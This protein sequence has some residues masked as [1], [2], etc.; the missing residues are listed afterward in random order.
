MKTSV[1]SLGNCSEQKY[2]NLKTSRGEC[3][4]TAKDILFRSFLA[5]DIIRLEGNFLGNLVIIMQLQHVSKPA[6]QIHA[7]IKNYLRAREVAQW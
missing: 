7:V 3:F 2:S 6:S 4:P 1:E 5:D